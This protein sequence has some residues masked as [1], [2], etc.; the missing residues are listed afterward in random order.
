MWQQHYP[1][2]LV[3]VS[4][5][6]GPYVPPRYYYSLYVHLFGTAAGEKDANPKSA[7]LA[8]PAR[9]ITSWTKVD[10][11]L[12]GDPFSITIPEGLPPAR[13]EV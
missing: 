12:V 11:L 7:S 1:P 9:L 10:E 2:G 8:V 6:G 13:Y 4:A 5:I 3:V